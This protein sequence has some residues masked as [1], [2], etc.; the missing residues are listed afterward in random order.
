M[1]KTALV[2]YHV[3]EAFRQYFIV[4]ADGVKGN[5]IAPEL[6][7]HNVRIRDVRAQS[8]VLNFETDSL[9]FLHAP[10]SITH[11]EAGNTCCAGYESE[12]QQILKAYVGATEVIVFDHTIRID[13]SQSVRK[14]V[15]HVHSDFSE[16]GANNRLKAILGNERA[17]EWAKGHFA[18]INVWRPIAR[19]VRNSNLGFIKPSSISNDEWESIGLKYP[20]REGEVMG[21]TH[22]DKHEWVYMSEM[23][24]DDIVIFNVYDNK[25]R[26]TAAHSAL[27]LEDDDQTFIRQSIESRLLV[28]F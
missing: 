14:P 10:S 13:Q 8:D 17:A 23:S 16:D 11:F 22:A 6:V 12:L 21:L 18:F 15:K 20:D 24:P 4:D 5:I 27:E 1:T 7:Q 25:G 9:L 19:P 28:R 26:P 3:K 2:N